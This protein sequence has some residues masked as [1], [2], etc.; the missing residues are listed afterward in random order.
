MRNTSKTTREQQA[1]LE[2]QLQNLSTVVN[3]THEG[4]YTLNKKIDVIDGKLDRMNERV[5][6][7]EQKI[8]FADKDRD[9]IKKDVNCLGEKIRAVDAAI[10]ERIR[11][12]VRQGLTAHKVWLY[13]IVILALINI[14]GF[15]VTFISR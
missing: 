11:E 15:I 13:G 9:E 5:I 1:V 12:G 10:G 8:E 3:S 4:I 6:I 14:L 2:V 7:A